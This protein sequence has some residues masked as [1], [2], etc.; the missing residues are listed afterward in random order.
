MYLIFS[1]GAYSDDGALNHLRLGI[2]WDDDAAFGLR[3][4]FG[5]LHQD[6]VQQWDNTFNGC[7]LKMES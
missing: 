2:F 6:A 5:T 7:R 3:Q 1:A 4:S